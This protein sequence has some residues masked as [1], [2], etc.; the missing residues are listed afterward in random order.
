VGRTA[1]DPERFNV[2]VLAAL[3]GCLDFWS[4]VAVG[5]TKLL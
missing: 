2:G 4:V 5:V 1:A 3:I